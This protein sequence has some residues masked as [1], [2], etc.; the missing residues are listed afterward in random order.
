VLDAYP[1]W[2][3]PAKVIAII[4]TADRQKATVKVRV[5]FDQLDPRILPE[6]GVKVSFLAD[7]ESAAA[8]QAVVIPRAALRKSD[9]RDVVWQ[10]SEGVVREQPVTVGVLRAEEVVV[11]EGLDPGDRILIEVPPKVVPGAKVRESEP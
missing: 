3:I 6:M 9:G 8:A 5:G 11:T 10:V 1:D 4:P 2:N 7:P